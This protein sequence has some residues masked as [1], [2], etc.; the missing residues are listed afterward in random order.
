MEYYQGSKALLK[1]DTALAQVSALNE[2][3]NCSFSEN[4]TCYTF[5]KLIQ[6]Q[7]DTYLASDYALN[8]FIDE[9]G[10]CQQNTRVQT[11]DSASSGTDFL[12]YVCPNCRIHEDYSHPN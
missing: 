12:E 2:G 10:V 8:M 6:E 4:G 5:T 1:N 3:E 11:K 9:C 7:V